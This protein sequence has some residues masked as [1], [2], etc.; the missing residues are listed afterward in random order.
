MT[1]TTRSITIYRVYQLSSHRTLGFYTG[2][3]EAVMTFCNLKFDVSQDD[4]AL[5][6]VPVRQVTRT[7]VMC[8][9]EVLSQLREHKQRIMELEAQADEVGMRDDVV[10]LLEE[11]CIV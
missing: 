3:E 5:E 11:S 6:R 2:D 7:E 4:I 9:G 8:F 10:K 1:M